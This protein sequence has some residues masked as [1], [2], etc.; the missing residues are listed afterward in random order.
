M[1]YLAKLLNI[2]LLTPITPLSR[3]LPAMCPRIPHAC[4]CF[5]I[6]PLMLCCIGR[7]IMCVTPALALLHKLETEPV[8][9][10][11]SA[12]TGKAEQ[13]TASD[14]RPLLSRALPGLCCHSR[15]QDNTLH[16]LALRQQCWPFASRWN[17]FETPAET[18]HGHHKQAGRCNGLPVL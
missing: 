18:R 14:A 10:S 2:A 12:A 17:A 9:M 5:S 3:P 16:L 1:H 13:H 7:K 11:T 15:Q 6:R 8:A 4:K